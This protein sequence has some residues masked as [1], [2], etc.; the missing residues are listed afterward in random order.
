MYWATFLVRSG[1]ACCL[2][3]DTLNQAV[4]GSRLGPLSMCCSLSSEPVAPLQ[5]SLQRAAFVG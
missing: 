4:N 3:P 5:P 1:Q 2:L